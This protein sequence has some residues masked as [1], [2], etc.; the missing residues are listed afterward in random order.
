MER[1][2]PAAG[3]DSV[4]P[5]YERHR[6]EETVLYG[7]VQS[8]LESFLA[9]VRDRP[10]PRFVVREFRGFLEC[11]ILAHGFLRVHCDAC[12]RDRIVAFSCKGRGFCPSCLGRRMA[13]TAAHLVDRVLPEVAVRQWVLSLPFAL[14]YRLAYGARLVTEVL[15]LFVRAVFASLRRRARWKWGIRRGQCGAATG[16][17]RRRRERLESAAVAMADTMAQLAVG[18]MGRRLRGA[19]GLSRPAENDVRVIVSRDHELRRLRALAIR[20][21]GALRQAA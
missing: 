19:E 15:D 16:R 5:A 21:R 1:L 4:A 20:A 6:P 3:H 9:R 11:G 10:L 12:G 14:R 8:E 18:L 2:S 17:G 7:V 13:D